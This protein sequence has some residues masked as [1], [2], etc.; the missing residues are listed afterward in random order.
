MNI[1]TFK[2][3][4]TSKR[5]ALADEVDGDDDDEEQ[6][7]VPLRR[8]VEGEEDEGAEKVRKLQKTLFDLT[9]CEYY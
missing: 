4:V 2:D 8:A 9:N 1:H 7:V 3:A 6:D 5:R